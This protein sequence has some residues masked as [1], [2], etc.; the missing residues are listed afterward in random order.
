MLITDHHGKCMLL[1]FR[2]AANGDKRVCLDKYLNLSE[3]SFP[4][5]TS[6]LCAQ[7]PAR[8]MADDAA[9][10]VSQGLK[11]ACRENASAE[12]EAKSSILLSVQPDNLKQP[13]ARFPSV[14]KAEAE[15]VGTAG[16]GVLEE[17]S[18]ICL[19]LPLLLSLL[20]QLGNA[21]GLVTMAMG[22]VLIGGTCLST[23]RLRKDG[24]G[25]RPSFV[26]FGW[27]TVADLCSHFAPL[28]STFAPT[29][30]HPNSGEQR[31]ARAQEVDLNVGMSKEVSD[32]A[33]KACTAVAHPSESAEMTT[34]D[35][36]NKQ[37]KQEE[38]KQQQ[39]ARKKCK[40]H[41]QEEKK[42][43]PSDSAITVCRILA[44]DSPDGSEAM[45][46]AGKLVAS[47]FWE[48][49]LER[50]ESKMSAY[51]VPGDKNA[52]KLKMAR[53]C[54]Q[55]PRWV[56]G[57]WGTELA[58][59]HKLAIHD[60]FECRRNGTRVTRN[61]VRELKQCLKPADS[62][63]ARGPDPKEESS[64]A[65]LRKNP[66]LWV[67]CFLL[68]AA[69]LM[70]LMPP[71]MAT[72]ARASSNNSLP[73][74]GCAP[75]FVFNGYTASDLAIGLQACKPRPMAKPSGATGSFESLAAPVRAPISKGVPC[76][77]YVKA[78]VSPSTPKPRL[79]APLGSSP[80]LV[81]V[82]GS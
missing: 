21:L 25:R 29:V 40:E 49:I 43:G 78:D 22:L 42:Q 48:M 35:K 7:R 13:A 46:L 18:L 44:G 19:Q 55:N 53:K 69:A 36:L 51:D 33:D 37:K 56:G 2:T 14:I 32:D 8:M 65:I 12:P 11:K 72:E 71:Q 28:C 20:P 38:K 4:G 61:A 30:L 6:C 81:I 64:L 47:D 57:S 75:S 80:D 59:A 79:I 24:S 45:S 67:P 26:Q 58:A 27:S 41:Q 68:A 5:C 70:V 54:L 34:S 3:N 50:R 15:E 16:R 10:M 73:A 9:Q 1:R 77:T 62:M 74:L 63:P 76:T 39:Q 66:G 17:S 31:C 82:C 60:V 23:S 52:M